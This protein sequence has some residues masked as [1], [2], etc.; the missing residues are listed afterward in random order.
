MNRELFYKDIKGPTYYRTAS[1]NFGYI[2]SVSRTG[3]GPVT[4]EYASYYLGMQKWDEQFMKLTRHED[5]IFGYDYTL[6]TEHFMRSQ[7][8]P[9]CP[10]EVKTKSLNVMVL[11][12]LGKTQYHTFIP[13]SEMKPDDIE[14]D[15]WGLDK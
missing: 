4:I 5:D 13:R 10:L 12:S 1:G 2:G 3:A 6:V 11:R 9:P 8:I 14:V 7:G 15:I